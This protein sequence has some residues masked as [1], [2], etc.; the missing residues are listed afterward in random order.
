[1][2]NVILEYKESKRPK[3]R[4]FYNGTEVT[5]SQARVIQ[6]IG[7]SVLTERTDEWFWRNWS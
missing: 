5:K 4:Y 6:Q 1:M 7:G 3:R 2:K